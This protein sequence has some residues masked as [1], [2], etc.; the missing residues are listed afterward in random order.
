MN[1]LVIH[2]KDDSTVFLNKVYENLDDV[3]L[4]Q[5]GVSRDQLKDMVRSHDQIMMMGH[6]TPHGLMSVGQFNGHSYV[7]DGSFAPLLAEKS[8]SV[9][10]WCNADEYVNQNELKGFFTGM[11]ISEIAEAYL[12]GLGETTQRQVDESNELFV[13][14]VGAFADRE[15]CLI[16][17]AAKHRYGQITSRNHVAKYNHE[18]LYVSAEA[19]G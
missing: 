2:P 15:P 17:A 12:M 13:E 8:N 19:A 5:G 4:V 10:I 9:F 6:G 14:T 3:T 7:V 18:R 11:Y 16:H 1:T